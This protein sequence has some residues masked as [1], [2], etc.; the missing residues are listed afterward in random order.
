DDLINC[1]PSQ[2]KQACIA[3]LV[4]ASEAV[5]GIQGEIVMQTKNDA[6]NIVLEIIDNGVGISPED[7]PHV[8]EPFYSTKHQTSGIGLGLAIVHGII[9]NHNGKIEIISELQK[10]ANVRITLPL[11]NKN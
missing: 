10:G 1:N 11:K 8:F 7:L 9:Q 4:N 5:A 6:N 3:I 2:I